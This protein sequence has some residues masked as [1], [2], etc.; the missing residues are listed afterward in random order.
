MNRAERLP[1]CYRKDEYGNIYK[2]LYLNASAIEELKEDI[3]AVGESLDLKIA[4]GKTLD[5]Y[6]EMVEQQRGLLNDEQYRYMIQARIGRNNVQGSYPSVMKALLLMFGGKPGDITLEDLELDEGEDSCVVKLSKFPVS[7]LVNAG[8]SSRQVVEMVE[9][10]LPICVKLFADNFEG[11][12][13]F[14]G[15]AMEY[16]AETGFADIEQSIGGYL[17]L[18]LGEDDKIPVLPL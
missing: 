17:G 11:T 13:T 6:G 10:L 16:D 4:T 7:V 5:L 9:R 18:L 15:E 14:S 3:L 2:L 12:F 1:D 8:F